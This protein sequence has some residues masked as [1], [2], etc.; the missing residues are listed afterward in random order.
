MSTANRPLAEM[1][2]GDR[3]RFRDEEWTVK[4]K[5]LYVVSDRYEETQWTLGGRGTETRYLV[6]AREKQ[7]SGWEDFWVWT[8][9]I[10]LTQV[11]SG[12][13]RGVWQPLGSLLPDAPP[14]GLRYQGI[15]YGLHA[16]NKGK[17]RDDEGNLVPKITWDYYDKTQKRNLAIEIW[18]E[19]DGD[20]PE[21]YDGEEVDPFSLEV[22]KSPSLRCVPPNTAVMKS[23]AIILFASAL[24]LFPTGV[25][26]DCILAGVVPLFLLACLIA[27]YVPFAWWTAFVVGGACAAAVTVVDTTSCWLIGVIC[28]ALS[29]ILAPLVVGRR[30]NAAGEKLTFVAWGAVLPVLWVYSFTIYFS[31][32]PGPREGHHL[33]ATCLVP[34]ALSGICYVVM[35]FRRSRG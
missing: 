3:V 22:S 19:P 14:Q 26:L 11:E 17:A 15:E 7:T 5:D 28:L 31:Y 27:F 21:A 29:A 8:K 13:S 25:P 34:L 9:E 6:L 20:Y 35:S 1:E 30:P 33:L 10:P 18:R 23:A 32:A 4:R 2:P 12:I 16:R 24:F